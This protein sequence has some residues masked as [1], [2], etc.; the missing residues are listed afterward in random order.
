MNSARNRRAASVTM[1]STPRD[2]L[3]ATDSAVTSQFDDGVINHSCGL[4]ALFALPSSAALGSKLILK[5]RDIHFR[6]F[7]RNSP[8]LN[9]VVHAFSNVG[10][11]ITDALDVFDRK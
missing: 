3:C 11:M 5:I 9:D 6:A 7:T 2:H 4:F 10:C 1:P 8:A